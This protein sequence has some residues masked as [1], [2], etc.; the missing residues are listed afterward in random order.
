[1]EPVLA[2]IRDLDEGQLEEVVGEMGEKAYR[3]RQLFEWVHRKR[4]CDYEDM[5]NLPAKLREGL[6]ERF[7]DVDPLKVLRKQ[8]AQD[9]STAK[10]LFELPDGNT[11]ESVWMR[12]R[13]GD[14][15][16][17]SSQVGCRM[18]C[19]FCASTLGGLIRNLTP[20]E[21]L[22]QVY[23]IER[24]QYPEDT[25][26][27][28]GSIIV[29]GMGEPFDNYENLI[30]FIRLLTDEKGRNL[31]ARSVTVSTCG[32]PDGIR[33]LAEEG[34]PVTLALSLHA[35]NDEIRRQIM[36]VAKAYP[37][38]EVFTACRE[39]FSKTG[40]RVSFEYSMIRDVNDGEKEARELSEK[41]GKLQKN[42][43]PVHINLIPLNAVSETGLQ[44]TGTERIT[45]FK[46][47]LEKNRINV[48]IRRE[49][50]SEIDAACGQL[51]RKAAEQ[52]RAAK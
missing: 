43:M 14:S 40:R 23:D 36:P 17:V 46:K 21:M 37:M 48:T 41:C 5:R 2:N 35:P 45:Q 38:E 16:C 49:M 26:G 47:T 3:G 51:R 15:V 33:R 4:V 25:D 6:R 1:M 50:G 22:S 8:E 9:G 31:S 7:G 29:M 39:Y 10:Y 28:I 24:E 12:Y 42:G 13:H 30:R 20:G 44:R 19:R 34:L 11:V 18:G 27:H 52:R 32:I